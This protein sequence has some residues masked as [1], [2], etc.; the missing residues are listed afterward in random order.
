[1]AEREKVL[2]VLIPSQSASVLGW[3]AKGRALLTTGSPDPALISQ[4]FGNSLP[5]ETGG[6]QVEKRIC[7]WG[8]LGKGRSKIESLVND[9]KKPGIWGSLSTWAPHKPRKGGSRWYTKESAKSFSDQV[10]P[11]VPS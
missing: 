8:G 6:E 10:A 4:S 2:R 9:Q 3:K 11:G 7:L 5:Y 1:L